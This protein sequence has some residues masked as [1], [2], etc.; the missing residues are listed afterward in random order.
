MN[1]IDPRSRW[2]EYLAEHLG[3]ALLPDDNYAV[4]GATTGSYNV[5]NGEL[6]HQK[7]PGLQ[8]QIEAFLTAGGPEAVDPEAL[9]V[10]W[11]GANDLLVLAATER[12]P[13]DS[14]RERVS[15]T[16]QAIR[17]LRQAGARHF[18]LLNVPDLGLTPDGL[19]SGRSEAFTALVTAYNLVLADAL[20]VLAES[21]IAAIQVDAFAVLQAMVN[22]REQFGFT[23]VKQALCEIDGDPNRFLFWDKVHPT[24]RGHE[25][26]AGAARERLADQF[27]SRPGAQ[28]HAPVLDMAP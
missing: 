27:T 18:L 14:I 28:R 4:G 21:G 3:I 6:D 15:N 17:V 11:I 20:E 2:I 13:E 24:T 5:N 9:Y 25:V 23:D 26:L 8:Q 12:D 7:Y 10:V 16:V 1:R 19:A 22:S